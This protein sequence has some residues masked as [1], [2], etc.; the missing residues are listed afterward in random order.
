[1]IRY[2]CPDCFD[3]D[4]LREFVQEN[5][6]AEECSF[7]GVRGDGPIAAEISNVLAHIREC[8]E[9]EYDDAANCLPY[10]SAEGGYIGEHWDSYE[11]L[12]DQI[13]LVLPRDQDNKLF[14]AILD[15]L[16]DIVWCKAHPFSLDHYQLARFSWSEFCRVVK[17]ERRFFFIDYAV[18]DEETLTP[19]RLLATVVRYAQLANL[20]HP[21]GTDSLL[22]RARKE[23]ESQLR[24]PEEL[25][26][27]PDP[28]AVRS[29]R[30]S[31]AGIVMMYA[32]DSA[33]TA[34][35]ETVRGQGTYAVGVFQV[36]RPSLVLDLTALKPVPSLFALIADSLEYDLRQ[37]LI[38]LRQ[39]A[40]EIAR[41]IARDDRAHIEYVPTQVV[42][43]YVR[44]YRL[45]SGETI[46]GI[47]Y[48]SSV[49]K[50]G[51]S[52]VLFAT[53][54]NIE[55]HSND[56]EQKWIRFLRASRRQV[57]GPSYCSLCPKSACPSSVDGSS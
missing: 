19:G 32:S 5:A 37:V 26:P 49:C 18:E 8:I 14:D 42:T 48:P 35:A 50:M 13:Q 17:H 29:N 51:A 33:E 57:A 3:D 27:P 54:R 36:T 6:V 22:Y 20:I 25:G 46:Q 10:E 41:P 12:T 4:G 16:E 39:V 40:K 21:L 30:M 45:P 31:P 38:F 52:Y 15:S 43:E 23:T 47:K 34:L 56:H 2:V 1:M 28:K 9:Q 7:C 55:G 24:T 44:S 53:Q 11:L